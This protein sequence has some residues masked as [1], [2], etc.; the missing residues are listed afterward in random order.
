MKKVMYLSVL[1]MIAALGGG[2]LWDFSTSGTSAL[3]P[4]DIVVI[5]KDMSFN[6][7]NPSFVVK[8]GQAI[9]ITVKNEDR[10]GIF[11]DFVIPALGL[12]TNFLKPGESEIL[13]FTAD[14]EGIFNYACTLHPRLMT[15]KFQVQ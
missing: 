1:I 4:I 8:K 7:T 5:A 12:K 11:H 13:L 9:R 6:G 10:P 14:R 3:P 2:F 15:G